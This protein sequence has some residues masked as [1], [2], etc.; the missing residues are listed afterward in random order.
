MARKLKLRRKGRT[1]ALGDG[2][3]DFTA[4]LTTADMSSSDSEAASGAHLY[5]SVS[6]IA[7]LCRTVPM[8]IKPFLVSMASKRL[9]MRLLSS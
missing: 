6:C 5:Q 1:S 9:M 2:L 7:V 4:G 8:R 3:D